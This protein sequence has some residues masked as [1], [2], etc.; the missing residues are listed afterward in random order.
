MQA[1]PHIGDRYYQ[2]FQAGGVLDT[3]A[4]L[5]H[6]ETH[7]TPI[8]TFSNVLRTED[9]SVREPFG[10]DHKI[11]A[12]GLGLIGEVKFD[13]EDDEIIETIR[14]VSVELNGVPV[15]EL[16][17][18]GGFMGTN[19]T[20]VAK[21]AI[22]FEGHAN[23]RSGEATVLRG[24]EVEGDV[25]INSG[26]EAFVVDSILHDTTWIWAEEAVTF[27]G[28][29][30]EER[31]WIR[32]DGDVNFFDSDLDEVRIQFGAGDNL[33]VVAGSAIDR[34]LADGGLGDNTFEDRGGNTIGQLQLTRF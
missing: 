21:E 23:I 14:I 19:A 26:A 28:S 10:L 9:T 16:V 32:G 31:V 18:P 7:T 20:G 25:L 29:T 33:L 11:Y 27:R 3:G 24:A 1:N 12:P 4:V 22:E 30:A 13:I 34:L 5:A 6:D 15:T 2:E 17:P 8:G